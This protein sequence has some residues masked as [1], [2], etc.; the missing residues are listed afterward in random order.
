MI[1]FICTM[2]HSQLNT[3]AQQELRKLAL[4][5][6]LVISLP[7]Q[8]LIAEIFSLFPLCRLTYL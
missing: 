5:T 2:F 7:L 4:S 8:S 3:E 1:G 6:E